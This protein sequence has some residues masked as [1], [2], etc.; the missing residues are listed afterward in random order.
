[1]LPRRTLHITLL[2]LCIV[3]VALL[4]YFR[5]AVINVVHLTTSHYFPQEPGLLSATPSHFLRDDGILEINPNSTH[6]IHELVMNARAEWSTKLGRAS[7]TLGEAVVE[8]KRRYSRL[9]PRGFDKWWEYAQHHNVQLP[10][11]YDQIWRDLEPFWG[12]NPLD[13]EDNLVQQEGGNFYIIGKDEDS[14][15]TLLRPEPSDIPAWEEKNYIRGAYEIMDLLRTIQDDLPPFRALISSFDNPSLLN[16]YT[17]KSLAIAAATKRSYVNITTLPPPANLGWASAC[18]PSSPARRTPSSAP[19]HHSKNKTFVHTH[20]ATMDP[21]LHPSLLQQHG[22]FLGFSPGPGPTPHRTLTPVFS[23]CA[24]TLHQDIQLPSMLSWVDD[25]TPRSDDPEWARKRDERLSWRGSN[26]GIWHSSET[27][28]H[29]AQRARLVSF[30]GDLDG[31]TKV[32]V[33]S[34]DDSAPVGE[35]REMK[36]AAIN[37]AMLDIAFAGA[38]IGCALDICEELGKVFEWRRRQ[39]PREVGEF[40]YIIDVD[41]NGWSSRFKRLMTSNSLIFKATIYPEW[42]LDRVQPWVH[43]VPVQVDLSDVY[44]A[45]VFFRGGMYGEGAHDEL[46]REIASAGRAWS[47]A[48]WRKEDVTSYFFRLFLEYARIMSL[49]RNAMSYEYQSDS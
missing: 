45:L 16:D 25:I 24:T 15:I 21:C 5:T 33:P 36:R 2:S 9:P 30:A 22:Q 35:G 34:Q 44:D 32:L 49:D 26:T 41:G 7:K 17:I 1:M 42:F 6:P 19:E 43:Y 18:S 20:S 23:Y 31:S 12:V 4:A 8:Y 3:A 46:A 38:P 27:L 29:Q 37:P 28:W 10:D 48:F 11:E 40:K 14:G 39:G 47:K 13:L